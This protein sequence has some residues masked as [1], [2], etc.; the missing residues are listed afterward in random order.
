MMANDIL[1]AVVI[2]DGF[3]FGSRHELPDLQAFLTRHITIDTGSVEPGELATG[4]AKA[5]KVYRPE[6]DLYLLSDRSVESIAGS[7]RDGAG[8]PHVPPHRGT[9][10]NTSFHPRRG[11]RPLRDAG[12]S[13]I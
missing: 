1:Q 12:I 4:L 10:G 9:N 11:E 7:A 5:I 2:I 6:L 3:Q 13:T 8:A